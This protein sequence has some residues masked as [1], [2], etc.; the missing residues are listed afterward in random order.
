MICKTRIVAQKPHGRQ[1]NAE[2]CG[3]ESAI[4]VIFCLS[5]FIMT[6]LFN[7]NAWKTVQVLTIILAQNRYLPQ[8]RALHPLS[9]HSFKFTLKIFT[10]LPCGCCPLCRSPFYYLVHIHTHSLVPKPKTTV[11]GLGVRLVH[12]GN[13]VL[14]R[15]QSQSSTSF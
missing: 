4:F 2:V 3:S 11:I 15:I 13:C 8:H 10:A 1:L 7:S 12:M 6:T 9:L 14:T 5:F